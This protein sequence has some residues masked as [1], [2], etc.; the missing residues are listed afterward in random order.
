VRHRDKAKAAAYMRAK[1]AAAPEK[2]RA[3]ARRH[4]AENRDRINAVRTK[5]RERNKERLNAQARLCRPHRKKEQEKNRKLIK[6]YGITRAEYEQILINQN[7]KCASCEEDFNSFR[8]V[9]DH[10]HMFGK[11]R[12]ILC[13]KCNAGIGMFDNDEEKLYKAIKYLKKSNAGWM[14]DWKGNKLF[15]QAQGQ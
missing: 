11:V 10:D 15:L 8:P 2:E 4:Y 12:G 13:V 1:R 6:N 9:V 7:N 3:Y 14:A 5:W